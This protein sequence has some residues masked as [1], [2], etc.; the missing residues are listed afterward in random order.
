M[1]LKAREVE[2]RLMEAFE[3]LI[4]I[5]ELQGKLDEILAV[6]GVASVSAFSSARNTRRSDARTSSSSG[7]K[8]GSR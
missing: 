2:I 3:F 4:A 6:P 8:S 1:H 5:D 7:T